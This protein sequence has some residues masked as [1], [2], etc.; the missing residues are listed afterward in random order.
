MVA[1]WM[2]G[3]EDEPERSAEICVCEIFGNEADPS[4]RSSR[5]GWHPFNDPAIRDDFTKIE[6]DIDVSEWHDYAAVWTPSDVTFFID[7]EPVKHVDSP[8]NT[9]CSRCS[10]STTSSHK[11]PAV[12]GRPS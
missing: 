12:Q 11:A 9:R 5:H 3:Y 7:D 8:R 4:A 10:T 1:L 2:I 6:A